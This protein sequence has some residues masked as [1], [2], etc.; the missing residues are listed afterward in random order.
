[1]E[2]NI[3]KIGKIIERW[4]VLELSRK[5]MTDRMPSVSYVAQSALSYPATRHIL[6]SLPGLDMVRSVFIAYNLLSGDSDSKALKRTET[7]YNIDVRQKT[8]DEYYPE[9]YC[10]TCEGNGEVY[11]EDCDGEGE[12]GCEH[13]DSSGSITCSECDGQGKDE[14]DDECY[15]C[16]GEG[17]EQCSD[18]DG[19]GTEQCRTC[20]GSGR[21]ECPECGGTGE[22]EGESEVVDIQY[23]T[24]ITQNKKFIKGLHKRLDGGEAIDDYDTLLN[25]YKGEILVTSIINDTIDYYGDWDG[26][27]EI[28]YKLEGITKNRTTYRLNR[29]NKICAY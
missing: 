5:G 2:E 14:D 19:E 3:L 21:Y 28:E 26:D 27:D 22:I 20:Y 15:E 25:E 29:E 13:C 16:D 10:D 1:M 9:E 4:V 8:S 7:I 23:T 12:V 11:C 18:C 24:V 6:E 17:T